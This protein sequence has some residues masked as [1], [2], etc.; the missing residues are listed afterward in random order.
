MTLNTAPIQINGKKLPTTNT[1]T[2]FGSTVHNDGGASEN[3]KNRIGKAWNIFII[4][5]NV[6]KSSQYSKTT[7][8]KLYQSCILSTLLYGSECWKMTEQDQTKLSTFHTKCFRRILRVFW[9]NTISNAEILRNCYRLVMATILQRRRW[10]WIG[11]VIR[12]DNTY[13]TKIALH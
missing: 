13:H 4:L 12:K 7:K 6:W 11:Y 2:Y 1:F 8:L 3:I 9:P 5:N 10:K